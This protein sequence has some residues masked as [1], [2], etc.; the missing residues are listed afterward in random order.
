MLKPSI[1]DY[2]AQKPIICDYFCVKPNIQKFFS[3]LFCDGQNF[4][5]CANFIL[6]FAWH[7]MSE[8]YCVKMDLFEEN[9]GI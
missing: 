5:D 8:P 1:L 3:F 6:F 9:F 7:A 2:L 4:L